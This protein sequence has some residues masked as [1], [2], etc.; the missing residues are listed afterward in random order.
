M[1]DPASAV[2]ESGARPHAGGPIR[3]TQSFVGVMEDVWRTPSLTGLEIAWRWLL[4]VPLLLVI[5]RQLS[6][7]FSDDPLSFLGEG[8]RSL[9]NGSLV[10]HLHAAAFALPAALLLVWVVLS[11]TGRRLLLGRL[12]HAQRGSWM[13]LFAV[14]LIRVIAFTAVTLCWAAILTKLGSRYLVA[15][16]TLSTDPMFVVAFAGA[17]AVTLVLFIAWALSSWLFRL[18]AVIAADR[19]LG[20]VAALRAAAGASRV[21][22]KLI[23]INLVMGIVKI[24]LMVLALV[25]S[26]CPLPFQS[27]ATQTFLTRWWLGVGLLYVLASDYFHVVRLGAYVRLYHVLQAPA[28]ASGNPDSA[29]Q[30]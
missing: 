4:G 18:A 16:E 29:S 24:A 25:F 8:L 28:L 23:E 17:V 3:G 14:T 5:W 15:P 20:A 10:V 6:A 1:T 27:V 13:S 19:G 22:G 26:A 2:G 30:V 11:A 12:E 21:R 9:Q 7:G